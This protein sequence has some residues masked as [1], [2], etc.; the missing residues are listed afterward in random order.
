MLRHHSLPGGLYVTDPPI[1]VHTGSNIHVL[2]QALAHALSLDR[3]LLVYAD[4]NH[5]FYDTE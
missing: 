1:L 2:G 4:Q 3:I 5:P